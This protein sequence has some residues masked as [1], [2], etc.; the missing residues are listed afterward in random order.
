[1]SFDTTT[2]VLR[3]RVVERAE[4]RFRD[5][6]V[7]SVATSAVA[8]RIGHDNNTTIYEVQRAER[9]PEIRGSA[10]RD[11]VKAALAERATQ[12]DPEPPAA[13]ATAPAERESVAR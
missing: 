9:K 12:L 7:E 13:S 5:V 1:M 3:D 4:E 10:G 6:L 8:S 2:R 11:P